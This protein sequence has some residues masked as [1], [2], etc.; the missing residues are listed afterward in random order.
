MAR[1]QSNILSS[2]SSTGDRAAQAAQRGRECEAEGAI[3]EKQRVIPTLA[4][5][6]TR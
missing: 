1:E 3:Q 4:S 6:S 5:G 2:S